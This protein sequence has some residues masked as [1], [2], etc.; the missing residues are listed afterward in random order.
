MRISFL[1]YLYLPLHDWFIT[2]YIYGTRLLNISRQLT[3]NSPAVLK[4][5]VCVEGLFRDPFTAIKLKV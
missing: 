5:S 2:H 4:N 1:F 3:I